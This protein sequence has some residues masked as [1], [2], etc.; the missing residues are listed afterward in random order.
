[1]SLSGA[2]STARWLDLRDSTGD[3]LREALPNE[4]KAWR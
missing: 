2:A 1:M 3:A 4:E